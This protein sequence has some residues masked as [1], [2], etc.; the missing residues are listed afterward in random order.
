MK[1]DDYVSKLITGRELDAPG[2]SKERAK[3]IKE[4]LKPDYGYFKY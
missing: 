3:K 2:V 1:K 4:E